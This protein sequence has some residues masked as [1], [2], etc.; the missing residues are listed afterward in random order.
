MGENCC[1]LCSRPVDLP[2]F[3][4]KFICNSGSRVWRNFS[5][6][7]VHGWKVKRNSTVCIGSPVYSSFRPSFTCV[8]LHESPCSQGKILTCTVLIVYWFF[9]FVK[10]NYFLSPYLQILDSSEALC[11]EAFDLA[12]KI[13]SSLSNTQLIFWANLKAFVQ[14]IFDT[15]VLAVAASAK[16]QAYAKIKEVSFKNSSFFWGENINFVWMYKCILCFIFPS[17]VVL[18][19]SFL[20]R[21][22]FEC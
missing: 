17:A 10:C 18:N 21:P 12:W 3:C 19:F 13:I 16:G 9:F 22:R 20:K 4:F 14:F 11:I 5:N 2:P 7:T 8:W 1:A 6:V 15:E